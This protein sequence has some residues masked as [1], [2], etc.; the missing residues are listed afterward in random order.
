VGVGI[1]SFLTMEFGAPI[2]ERIGEAEETLAHGE[3]R[4]WIKYAAWRLEHGGVVLAA[5][6][7]DRRALGL[8][9]A[10]LEGRA[11][12]DVEVG[13]PALDTTFVFEGGYVLRVLAD[14]T[15]SEHWLLYV[16]DGNVLAVGPGAYTYERSDAA[17]AW[18]EED[19]PEP[20]ALVSVR[21]RGDEVDPAELTRQLELTPTR[22][23]VAG[24]PDPRRRGRP[25]FRTEW[26]LDSPLPTARPLVEHLTALLDALEPHREP[27]RRLAAAWGADVS[28]QCGI[29]AAQPAYEV[30]LS[31]ELA[32]RLAD[33]GGR[34]DVSVWMY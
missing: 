3:W 27:L 4:L 16:P 9:V 29:S 22:A 32:R 13:A 28:F 33:V 21:V 10:R 8:A 17:R 5:S 26:V 7:D 34:L 12:R 23:S 2:W 11:L 6:A 31:A 14:T 1:G 24:R 20:E 15:E 30:D 25:A 18:V 19:P